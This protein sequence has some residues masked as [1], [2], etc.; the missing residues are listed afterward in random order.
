MLSCTWRVHP[1]KLFALT[2]T[3]FGGVVEMRGALVGRS[4]GGRSA[5]R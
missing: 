1:H 3:I 2:R 4:G 5:L